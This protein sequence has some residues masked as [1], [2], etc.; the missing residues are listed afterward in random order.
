MNAVPSRRLIHQKL[1]NFTKRTQQAGIKAEELQNEPQ[2]L[3]KRKRKAYK[4]LAGS[5]QAKARFKSQ[6]S[7][8]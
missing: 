6:S 4:F 3:L 7:H 8:G 5:R 2:I 1:R